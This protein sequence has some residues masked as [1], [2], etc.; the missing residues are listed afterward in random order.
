M[1]VW[2]KSN[3]AVDDLCHKV[4]GEKR[5]RQ[6][7]RD[8]FKVAELQ[9]T[10]V[11][12]IGYHLNDCWNN[13]RFLKIS[14]NVFLRYIK[15]NQRK[16]NSCTWLRIILCLKVGFLMWAETGY[17]WRGISFC[18]TPQLLKIR[19]VTTVF[20]NPQKFTVKVLS[21]MIWIYKWKLVELYLWLE[22]FRP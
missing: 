2:F 12:C 11:T 4:A 18:F 6:D 10:Q 8:S 21:L 5:V 1:S 19:L 20:D 14:S 17:N 9:L 22:H 7:L 16:L 13:K 15:C 3:K